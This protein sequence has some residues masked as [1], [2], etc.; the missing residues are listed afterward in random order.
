MTIQ[1]YHA[2]I[3]SEHDEGCLV[4]TDDHLAALAEKD[5]DIKAWRGTAEILAKDIQKYEQQIA[6]LQKE[7]DKLTDR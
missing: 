6:A 4:L 7:I 1:R 2:D 3:I 5:V